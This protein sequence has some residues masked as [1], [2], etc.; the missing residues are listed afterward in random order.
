MR[1]DGF[2]YCQGGRKKKREINGKG[3]RGAP[4]E[5][6][7]ERAEAYLSLRGHEQTLYLNVNSGSFECPRA[8][9]HMFEALSSKITVN[10]TGERAAIW[11]SRHT[12]WW[13][14]LLDDAI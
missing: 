9:A 13:G 6:K 14:V 11:G 4:N 7:C 1:K 12:A 10:H 8:L 2:R 5:P 3:G